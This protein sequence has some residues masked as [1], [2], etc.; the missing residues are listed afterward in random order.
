[1][2]TVSNLPAVPSR[3]VPSTFST[4]FE[5]FLSAL[6]NTFVSEVNTVATIVMDLAIISAGRA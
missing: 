2:T 4:L 6:K 3:G 1:M 5:A